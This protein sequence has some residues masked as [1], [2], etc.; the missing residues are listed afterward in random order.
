VWRVYG[1]REERD[2]QRKIGSLSEDFESEGA[3]EEK[4]FEHLSLLQF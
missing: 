2:G 1:R 3:V 4:F